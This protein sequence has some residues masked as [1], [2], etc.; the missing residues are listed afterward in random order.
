MLARTIKQSLNDIRQLDA[1]S[2]VTEY[3]IRT[4][5]N[6]GT[7]SSIRRGRKILLDFEELLDYLNFRKLPKTPN[8]TE[9][10]NCNSGDS[11]TEIPRKRTSRF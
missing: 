10:T 8:H 3:A 11:D 1:N 2:A 7:I 9:I 5:V 4:W 6:N